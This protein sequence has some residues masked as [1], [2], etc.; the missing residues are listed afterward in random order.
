MEQSF[1]FVDLAG[2]TALTETHGDETGASLIERFI[3]IVEASLEGDGRLVAGSG[4]AAFMVADTPE[5]A[6]GV[7]ARLFSRADAETDFPAL[8]AGL[9]HG[10]AAQRGDQF[11][12]TAVNVAARVAA[13]ARGGQ[14]LGTDVIAATARERGMT[15]R[16]LGPVSLKNLRQP[17]ELFSVQI[18]SGAGFEVIDPVCRMR[19]VPE[20]AA[21]RL[22]LGG[23]EYWFCSYECLELFVKEGPAGPPPKSKASA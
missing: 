2:F 7:L 15:V 12:G 20:R 6:L 8:R 11:Y 14:L 18:A 23:E 19:V 22:E 9:H 10:E 3:R 1:I 13:Y 5:Q 4:D 16:P 21:A 17:L